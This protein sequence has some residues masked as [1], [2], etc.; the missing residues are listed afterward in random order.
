MFGLLIK[1]LK[2]YL[3][4][5]FI[6]TIVCIG[7]FPF[8]VLYPTSI[9]IGKILDTLLRSKNVSQKIDRVWDVLGTPYDFLLKVLER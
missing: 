5:I 7:V 3:I 9:L 1:V 6:L 4:F 8:V 2:H